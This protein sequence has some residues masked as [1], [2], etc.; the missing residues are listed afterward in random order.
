MLGADL[1][2][3]VSVNFIPTAEQFAAF[4]GWDP[5]AD[6]IEGQAEDLPVRRVH[7]LG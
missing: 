3:S 5:Q 1:E 2:R 7:E 6:T 4:M